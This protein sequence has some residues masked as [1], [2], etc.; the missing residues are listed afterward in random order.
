MVLPNIKK[1]LIV[2]LGGLGDLLIAL[3]A[4][5]ALRVSYPGAR[6]D[7]VVIGRAAEVARG[8]G[9]FDRVD[10]LSREI[11]PA[12]AL[13]ARLRRERYDLVVNMRPVA[14]KLGALKVRMLFAL[15]GG[16]LS[17]GRN[18]AGL[19]RFFDIAIAEPLRA[20]QHDIEYA[21]SLVAAL[22]GTVADKRVRFTV[23]SQS[24][25]SAREI[26]R[27]S[28]IADGAA[29]IGI[30]A[31]GMPS[32]RWPADRFAESIRKLAL[33]GGYTF[34][35]TGSADE[36]GYVE[37]LARD[38][39]VPVANL[40]GRLTVAE[41]AA[42]IKRCALYISNDTG[43]IHIAAALGTPLVA[44][45]GPGDFKRFDPRAVSAAAVSLYRPSA[46][47]P[48]DRSRCASPKCLTAIGTDEVI[49][50][51]LTLLGRRPR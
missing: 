4:L 31:G 6:C 21:S 48:C 8:A 27:A 36:R 12:I 15:I 9:I 23:E 26:L 5:R 51:A 45:F 14:S 39:G 33:L 1:I 7:A 2:E 32:H 30:H 40:A 19:A 28:G 46:C 47:A 49:E 16:R 29:V 24:A 38:A 43:P 44:I 41:L 25:D 22:G 3:P 34:V 17:A 20:E 11:V 50:A 18:T 42:V 10:V 13:I 37:S 35:L